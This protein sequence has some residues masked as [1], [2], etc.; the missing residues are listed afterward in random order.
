MESRRSYKKTLA[1]GHFKWEDE[2][3]VKELSSYI[4]GQK[5]RVI[6]SSTLEIIEEGDIAHVLDFHLG[7]SLSNGEP[8]FVTGFKYADGRLEQD[9]FLDFQISLDKRNMF[10]EIQ[11]VFRRLI[12]SRD[13][14]T[15]TDGRF[16][17]FPIWPLSKGK[18]MHC[19]F[20]FFQRT[21]GLT[22]SDFENNTKVRVELYLYLD[23]VKP[24]LTDNTEATLEK[25]MQ[26]L[27]LQG[28]RAVF[29]P[30]QKA[31]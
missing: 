10:G 13:G 16:Q 11:N 6:C 5:Y 19:W 29:A 22:C 9:A 7:M 25:S 4:P 20:P 1:F 12:A 18:L 23:H 31:P 24:R 28:V 8:H 2:M 15:F 17:S 30:V 26:K 14:R 27:C 3:A 21:H